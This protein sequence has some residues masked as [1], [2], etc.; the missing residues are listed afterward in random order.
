[1]SD[2]GITANAPALPPIARRRYRHEPGRDRGHSVARLGR[3]LPGRPCGAPVLQLRHAPRLQWRDRRLRPR[4]LLR[5]QPH[6]TRADGGL[7]HKARLGFCFTPPPA[8]GT[9]FPD[10]PASNI[11]AAWIEE[12]QRQG[13]T[14]GC[15]NGNY[16]PD[17]SVTRAQMAIFLL[18]TAYGPGYARPPRRARSS[19]TCPSGP[20][21]PPG[22]R[23]SWPAA[24][25]PAAAWPR[26]SIAP[27]TR[28]HGAR[29]PPSS[30]KPSTF[31]PRN[32]GAG[33]RQ[34]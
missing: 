21:G 15:G 2:T 24:S 19:T 30:S 7:P 1:M 32:G 25:R 12:L 26:R 11:Y 18:N 17:A 27:R 14:A 16:C 6:D 31:N 20:S 29:W 8:T 34:L 4:P 33:A 13:L 10:V 22:S 9:V 5:R 23:I 28:S 3:G